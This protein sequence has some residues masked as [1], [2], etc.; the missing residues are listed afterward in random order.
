MLPPA[1]TCRMEFPSLLGIGS[2]RQGSC[3]PEFEAS[4][5][6]SSFLLP[7]VSDGCF[8]LHL[9]STACSKTFRTF[10]QGLELGQ[11]LQDDG[12][13]DLP[14]AHGGKELVEFIR[15]GD[16]A[17]FVHHEM[18]VQG[19]PAAV[20]MVGQVVKL[21]EKLGV[22][23]PHDEIEAAVVVG[24]HGKEGRLFLPDGGQLHFIHRGDARDGGQVEL[25]Q[26]DA[27]AD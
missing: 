24:D 3:T 8:S 26:P 2:A 27:Q 7:S 23:H 12:D 9:S 19:Q 25:F 10:K 6:I 11:V 14:A 13:A 22:E 16:V 15:Q 18:D 20:N 4:V 17:E 5:L 1:L 21:L